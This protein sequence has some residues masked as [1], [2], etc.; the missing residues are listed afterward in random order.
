ML[1]FA[2]GEAVLRGLGFGSPLR[3][4][5]DPLL[6]WRLAPNQLARAPSYRTEYRTNSLGWRDAEPIADARGEELLDL[7]APFAAHAGEALFYD[8]VHPTPRGHAIAAEAISAR[9]VRRLPREPK[10]S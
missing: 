10:A 5:F 6:S 7:T 8:I 9:L 2:L 4:E 1:S 3:F